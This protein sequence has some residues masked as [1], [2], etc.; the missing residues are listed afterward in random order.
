MNDNGENVEFFRQDNTHL[1]F[2]PIAQRINVQTTDIY[3]IFTLDLDLFE[4]LCP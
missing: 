1:Y 3:T 4:H 2:R